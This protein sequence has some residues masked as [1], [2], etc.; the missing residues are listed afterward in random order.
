MSFGAYDPTKGK[1]QSTRPKRFYLNYGS[2]VY[3]VL[4][5]VKSLA[6]KNR[7]AQFW[8]VIWL[9]DSKNKARPVS[10]VLRTK[11][12]VVIQNDPVLDRLAQMQAE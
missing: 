6:S 7:I 3:R 12:K 11:D 4:P 8:S 1:Y 9:R 10:S 5:P 2:N